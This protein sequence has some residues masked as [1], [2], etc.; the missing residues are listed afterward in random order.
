[1]LLRISGIVAATCLLYLLGPAAA[2]ADFLMIP[3]P[4]PGYLDA[5]H[6]IPITG[7]DFN[8]VSSITDGIQTVSFSSA[9]ETRTVPGTWFIWGSPPETESS[10]PR[11]LWTGTSSTLTMDFTDPSTVF[12]FEAE[13]NEFAVDSITAQFFGSAGLEGTITRDVN[14]FGG[15]LLFAAQSTDPFTSVVVTSNVDFGIAEVRYAVSG[16]AIP[17][18][19]TFLLV[20][21]G[22]LY[23]VKRKLTA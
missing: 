2:R 6:K 20:A 16:Y 5:T 8:F 23:I 10:S 15:A 3:E 18:P 22:A 12:G 9:L 11:V 14:G 1:M 21:C 13:P 19:G 4:L 7:P 17:E